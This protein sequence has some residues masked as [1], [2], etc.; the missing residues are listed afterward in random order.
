MDIHMPEV[1]GLEA[2]RRIRTDEA[3]Y[4]TPIVAITALAMPGDREKCLAA[5]VD[6]YLT[7]PVSLKQ[8][9]SVIENLL[10]K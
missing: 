6:D 5:G 8:L 3:L 1:D 2:T 7:K 10:Y 4:K 9:T